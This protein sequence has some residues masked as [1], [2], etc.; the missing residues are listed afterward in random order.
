MLLAAWQAGDLGAGNALV[1]RYYHRVRHFF[2]TKVDDHVDDLT[3]QTFLACAASRSRIVDGAFAPFLFGIARNKLLHRLRH[4]RR[5]CAR[6]ER[7]R[8]SAPDAGA[9]SGFAARGQRGRVLLLALRRLPLDAQIALEVFYWEEMTIPE[10]AVVLGV[11]AGTVKARL[12][13]A[14]TAL[15]EHLHELRGT[16]ATRRTTATDLLQWATA[17]R[18]RVT[19]PSSTRPSPQR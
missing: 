7:F 8:S 18:P 9:S 4:A 14:R 11:P 15:R 17:R 10:I 2:S 3:Q 5:H 6:L 16:A 19:T 13:R 1:R 12:S